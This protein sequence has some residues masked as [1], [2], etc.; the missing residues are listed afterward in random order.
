VA[1]VQIAVRRGREAEDAG[2]RGRVMG[3]RSY[4]GWNFAL[5]PQGDGFGQSDRLTDTQSA[6]IEAGRSLPVGT[7]LYDR[8]ASASDTVCR[9]SASCG[10]GGRNSKGLDLPR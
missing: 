5:M 9:D 3:Q 6:Q 4:A 10:R 2:W 8:Q 7:M 1:E